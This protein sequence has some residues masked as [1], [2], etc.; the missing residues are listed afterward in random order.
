MCHYFSNLPKCFVCKPCTHKKTWTKLGLKPHERWWVLEGRGWNGRETTS[1][2]F[3][4]PPWHPHPSTFFIFLQRDPLFWK[5]EI[6]FSIKLTC[7]HTIRE[8]KIPP[9]FKHFGVW[10]PLVG[11][12]E[13]KGWEITSNIF[14]NWPSYP[15]IFMLLCSLLGSVY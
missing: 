11:K 2:N 12:G 14:L 5:H 4:H 10:L 8:N 7:T 1:N 15:N 3:F 6:K 9:F 13:R